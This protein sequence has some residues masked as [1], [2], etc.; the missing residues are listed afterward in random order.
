MSQIEN[1]LSAAHKDIGRAAFLI[2]TM[3]VKRKYW[4]SDVSEAINKLEQA[5]E[6]LKKL[7]QNITKKDK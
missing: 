5:T 4:G 3:L 7:N 2:V 1:E 6:R